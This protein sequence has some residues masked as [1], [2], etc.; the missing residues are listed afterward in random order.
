M[1]VEYYVIGGW[2]HIRMGTPATGEQWIKIGLPEEIWHAQS[3]IDQRMNVLEKTIE[4]LSNWKHQL[5][6]WNLDKI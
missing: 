4:A 5:T 3:K 1:P 6:E 2:M